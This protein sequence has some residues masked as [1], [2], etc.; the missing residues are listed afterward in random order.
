LEQG[1]AAPETL[2]ALERAA[3]ERRRTLTSL[4]PLGERAHGIRVHFDPRTDASGDLGRLDDAS[5][6][7]FFAGDALD[8]VE[9]T[10]RLLDEVHRVLRD[11]GALVATV[12]N[13]EPYLFV[14]S[15]LRWATN[16][17]RTAVM[18]CDELHDLLSPRFELLSVQG[19][20]AAVH[21][22]VD[23]RITDPAFATA[24]A[25][26]LADRP[27]LATNAVLMARRRPEWRPARRRTQVVAMDDPA[28]RWSGPWSS[29]PLH[30]GL[31]GRL[32]SGGDTS[33]LE[34]DVVGT[35]VLVFLWAHPWGGQTT[36][37]IDGVVRR[38]ITLYA[39][40]SGFRRVH[41][42]DLASA[43]H[44][45]RVRGSR[46]RPARSAADQLIVCKLIG[47]DDPGRPAATKKERLMDAESATEDAFDVRPGRFG[48]VYAT[49]AHMLATERVLLY[50]LVFA[51]RPQRSLEIGTFRGG[52][53]L[54]IGAALD[55]LGAGTLVCVDPAPQVAPEEWAL[56]GHRATL[57]GEPSP[58][59]L[60][61]AREIAGDPFDFV[62]VDGEHDYDGVVRDLEGVLPYLAGEAHVLVHDAHFVDVA[63]AVD[64]VLLKHVD[65][66]IDCG[67]LSTGG[68]PVP[69][70]VAGK[71][72][73]WGGLRLL[74]H[75]RM[76]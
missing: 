29:V 32:G 61:R 44:R 52:S 31:T 42:R 33:M 1:E 56:I 16:G 49:P 41:V 57:V 34:V 60:V 10:E 6:D 43:P 22:A 35:D 11:G 55:D 9:D 59:A 72:V 14:R 76:P 58:A 70:T 38:V 62:L 63:E 51:L 3:L 8:R 18:T 30:G 19:F 75:H 24:W 64:R 17:E 7:L 5:A 54:V 65:T 47:Y 74:R 13:A 50:A 45:V 4:L 53:A 66:L 23:E 68:K 46:A 73:V 67:M 12:S 26:Q 48:V 39:P 69:G 27:D 37:E 36:I 71:P 2:T 28:I 40:T 15:G 25:S 20:N 21:P